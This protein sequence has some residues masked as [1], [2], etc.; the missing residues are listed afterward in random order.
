MAALSLGQ[1]GLF[2]SKQTQQPRIVH[3]R[4]GVRRIEGETLPERLLGGIPIPVPSELGERH[5]DERRPER[6]INGQRSF[7]RPAGH[8]KRQVGLDQRVEAQKIVGIGQRHV[9][10]REVRIAL[11]GML[12][13]LDGVTPAA[14]EARLPK[15]QAA[16]EGVIGVRVLRMPPGMRTS[17]HCREAVA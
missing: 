7:G 8:G 16:F 10:E 6:R 14:L 3:V 9:R 15:M 4:Q 12:K 13:V 2:A 1:R 17:E 11:D 5:F